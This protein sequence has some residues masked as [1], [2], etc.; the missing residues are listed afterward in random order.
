[1][2]E[3]LVLLGSPVA[4]SL[5]PAMQDAALRSAGIPLR[6][7]ALD[8]APL[9]LPPTVRRL[10]V[11]RAAGNVTIPH[12]GAFAALCDRLTTPAARAGAV[13]TFWIANDGSLMG[14]NTDVPGFDA[15]ARGLLGTAPRDVRMLLLGAG[16]S[17]AAVLT[18]VEQWPG[19]EV[20]VWART[21]TRAAALAGRFAGIA[22]STSD[23]ALAASTSSLVV[24]ATPVGLHDDEMPLAP[25]LLAAGSIAL[26][27]VYRRGETTW[28]RA[29]RTRGL[30]AADG[31]PMLVEQG[32][33]AFERWFARAPDREAMWSAVR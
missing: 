4:H 30:R 20:M 18:A 6:Y 13:N 1:M 24:N 31:L 22:R 27:L 19:S 16:G 23:L 3:R 21:A 28:V 29:A 33:L 7:E 25:H 9:A 26:D 17:A 15:V 11:E 10:V 8:V 14:D 12:K 5:S 32:A 2:P